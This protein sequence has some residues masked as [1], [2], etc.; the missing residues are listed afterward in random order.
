MRILIVGKMNGQVGLASQIAIKRGAKV[1]MTDD[2]STAHT[3]LCSGTGGDMVLI[4]TE[5]D[6]E[7]FLANLKS[8]HI[9]VPVVACGSNIDSQRVSRLIKAG[10]REFIPLPP[11][12]KLIA[13]VLTAVTQNSEMIAY[14]P[15]MLAVISIADKIAPSIVNVMITGETGTGKEIIARYL[16]AKSERRQHPFIALNCA[17]IPENLLESELFGHEKGAFTG[18]I[19]RKIGKFEAANQGTLLLDEISEMDIRLQAKLLRVLQEREIDRVGGISPVKIDVRVLAT[20]NRNLAEEVKIGNF[21]EDL[22]FRL[23]VV[24]LHLPRLKERKKDIIPF[25]EHFAKKYSHIN[26]VPQCIISDDSRE[27]LTEYSWPGNVRELENMIHR[28]VLMSSTNTIEPD[29]LLMP[30]GSQLGKTPPQKNRAPSHTKDDQQILDNIAVIPNM[31][32][33]KTVAQVEQELIIDTLKYCFGNRSHAA[34]ILGISINT[35]RTKLN[36][37]VNKN[38][39]I[40]ACPSE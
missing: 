27:L 19:S 18:A 20:S 15:S 17:A 22:I 36:D 35:L 33:G 25:A 2:I 1:S 16:H 21:R 4:D 34:N 28:A 26:N 5:L 24:N 6:I 38:I 7:T 3:L 32:I 12:P 23:N 31:L 29:A 39:E 11:D 10:A 14:D 9:T 37:Y 13:A 8:Q 30:D 40:P